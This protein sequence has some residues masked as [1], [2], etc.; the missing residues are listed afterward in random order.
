MC[1]ISVH[2]TCTTLTATLTAGSEC[3]LLIG[4]CNVSLEGLSIHLQSNKGQSRL[5]KLVVDVI[6]L[7]SESW[8]P[9]NDF[10]RRS[11]PPQLSSVIHP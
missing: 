11:H 4:S 10:S 7:A 2:I 1:P 8:P 5:Y 6:G 3:P 9:C